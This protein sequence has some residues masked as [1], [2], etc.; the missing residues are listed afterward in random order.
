MGLIIW[1]RFQLILLEIGSVS[2]SRFGALMAAQGSE[3]LVVAGAANKG[4]VAR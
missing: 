3:Q 4:N 2:I 1:Q